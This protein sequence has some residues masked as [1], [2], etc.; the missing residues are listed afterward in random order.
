METEKNSGLYEMH[1]GVKSAH[2][3]FDESTSLHSVDVGS[4]FMLWL[5]CLRGE[6]HFRT[7]TLEAAVHLRES[8]TVLMAIPPSMSSLD[9]RSE[10]GECIVTFVGLKLL[11][12]L[13]AVNFDASNMDRSKFDY[14]TAPKVINLS[15]KIMVD[16]E[17]WFLESDRDP[18]K[19]IKDYGTFL[20]AFSSLMGR[21]FGRKMDKCPVRLDLEAEAA[22]REAHHKIISNLH[23]IPDTQAIALAV[24]LPENVLSEGFKHVYGLSIYKYYLDYKMEKAIALLGSGKKLVKEVAFELGYQ[25]PSH[26]IAAFKKKYGMTPKKYFQEV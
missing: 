20:G 15:P 21:L 3:S 1:E 14:S 10:N 23:V 11:H 7:D 25:S 18:F 24:K 2:F 4:R 26:F 13:L 8:E 9:L 5:T 17:N 19:K 16:L 22:L 12:E 6:V